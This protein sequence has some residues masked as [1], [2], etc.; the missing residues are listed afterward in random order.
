VQAVCVGGLVAAVGV[1]AAVDEE[2]FGVLGGGGVAA[3]QGG[4][5]GC[6]GLEAAVEGVG[7]GDREVRSAP[8]KHILSEIS[9][10]PLHDT[11][12]YLIN[13]QPQQH[14]AIHPILHPLLIQK[15]IKLLMALLLKNRFEATQL[16]TLIHEYI[17]LH[18]HTEDHVPLGQHEEE[19]A[20]FGVAHV[21]LG[22]ALDVEGVGDVGGVVE[23]GVGAGEVGW[24]GEGGEVF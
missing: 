3:E 14:P 13:T 21:E 11:L 4:G 24:G 23:G 20:G 10:N 18:E 1:V 8:P 16:R 17:D 9:T 22:L 19:V 12:Q 6:G 15:L 7:F 2:G 5:C